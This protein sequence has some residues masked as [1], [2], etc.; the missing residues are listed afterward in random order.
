LYLITS[1]I[2]EGNLYLIKL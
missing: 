1:F 2:L